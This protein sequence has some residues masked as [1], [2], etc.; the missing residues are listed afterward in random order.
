MKVPELIDALGELSTK[1]KKLYTEYKQIKEQEDALRQDLMIVLQE[2]GLR[3]AKTKHYSASVA[4]RSDIEVIHEQSVLEWLR[5][6]PNVEE[7]QYIG[8][9]RTE[10]K[11]LAK[12]VLKETGEIIPGTQTVSKD[13]LTIKGAVKI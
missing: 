7:D 10:F 1:G 3:S 4:T 2:T 6:E 12:Q 11:P 5:H 9:K 13:S 8:L